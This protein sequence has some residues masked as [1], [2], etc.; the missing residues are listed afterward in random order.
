M[1]DEDSTGM[2]IKTRRSNSFDSIGAASQKDRF[3]I[4]TSS[5]MQTI[6]MNDNLK[7]IYKTKENDMARLMKNA[8]LTDEQANLISSKRTMK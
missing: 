7:E 4:D 6:E 1:D 3:I 5:R 8:N 2:M